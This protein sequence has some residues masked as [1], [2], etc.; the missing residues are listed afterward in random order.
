LHFNI[1][2][3]YRF[4]MVSEE[5]LAHPLSCG[6][7]LGAHWRR[8]EHAILRDANRGVS[9]FDWFRTNLGIAPNILARRLAA[10]AEDGSLERRRHSERP[11]RDEYVLIDGR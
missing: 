7:R 6:Q 5:K 2:C 4:A 9:R 8:R 10:S 1:N 3:H 11:P